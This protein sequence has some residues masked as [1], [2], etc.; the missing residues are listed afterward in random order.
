[1]SKIFGSVVDSEVQKGVTDIRI[2]NGS[3][4]QGEGFLECL[5]GGR[6]QEV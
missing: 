6:S 2:F 3:S 4:G 1:M 5:K